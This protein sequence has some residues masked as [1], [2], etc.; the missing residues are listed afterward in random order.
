M[1]E[2]KWAK[3]KKSPKFSSEIKTNEIYAAIVAALQQQCVSV[4]T[5]SLLRLLKSQVPSKQAT[6]MKLDEMII[7]QLSIIEKTI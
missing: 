6:E 5:V 3:L 1:A 4:K 2:A 7:E